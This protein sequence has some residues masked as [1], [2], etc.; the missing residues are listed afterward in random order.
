MAETKKKQS[1]QLRKSRVAG[2][3]LQALVTETKK[4]KDA[5]T[6]RSLNNLIIDRTDLEIRTNYS[7]FF[8][9]GAFPGP[10]FQSL[11]KGAGSG[12]TRFAHGAL[13]M[14]VS[15]LAGNYT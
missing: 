9:L 6:I 12:Y 2:D 10:S 4:E 14:Q 8:Y 11:P 7:A 15:A 13:Q 1:G 5:A 3:D